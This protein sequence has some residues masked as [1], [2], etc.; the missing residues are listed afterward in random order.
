[1]ASLNHNF[2]LSETGIFLRRAVDSSG[3]T[4]GAFFTTASGGNAL[5]EEDEPVRRFTLCYRRLCRANVRYSTIASYF[6]QEISDLMPH[7][8]SDER[9]P[10]CLIQPNVRLRQADQR[11]RKQRSFLAIEHRGKRR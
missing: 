4:G 5:K 2:A 10:L 6:T 8:A 1:M 7:G 9:L 3:K 11:D